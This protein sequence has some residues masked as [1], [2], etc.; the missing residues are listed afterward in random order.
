MSFNNRGNYGTNSSP[1]LE[2][3]SEQLNTT[4]DGLT[5]GNADFRLTFRNFQP[6]Q[7]YPGKHYTAKGFA[8][9]YVKPGE[10]AKPHSI[11]HLVLLLFR[12]GDGTGDMA[13]AS[14]RAKSSYAEIM[15]PLTTICNEYWIEDI[16]CLHEITQ[17]PMARIES[18]RYRGTKH[19]DFLRLTA[20]GH[21]QNPRLGETIVRTPPLSF[22]QDPMNGYGNSHAIVWDDRVKYSTA[23]NFMQIAGFLAF[24]PDQTELVESLRPFTAKKKRR[25]ILS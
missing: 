6:F 14:P 16:A 5:V 7:E 2:T 4:L 9:V 15:V 12:P 11:G 10:I 24:N 3:I 1:N 8:E 17:P 23:I 22:T 18:N 20:P 19:S 25:I 21:L 13:P